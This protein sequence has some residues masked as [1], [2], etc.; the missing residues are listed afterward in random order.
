MEE[1][2]TVK[3]LGYFSKVPQREPFIQELWICELAQVWTDSQ[4]KILIDTIQCS[5]PPIFKIIFLLTHI[6]QKFRR[7]LYLIP[8]N[9]MSE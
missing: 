2:L 8:E 7:L 1:R 5:P 6:K 9:I 4:A 3:I